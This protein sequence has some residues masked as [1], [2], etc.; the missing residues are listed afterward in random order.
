[1]DFVDYAA[2]GCADLSAFLFILLK[3]H[4]LVHNGLVVSF[5]FACLC[6]AISFG[7]L[8]FLRRPN[9]LNP[10]CRL[11]ITY[12][13][14][15]QMKAFLG[16]A[17]FWLIFSPLNCLLFLALEFLIFLCLFHFYIY[18]SSMKDNDFYDD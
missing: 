8:L 3:Q 15:L 11:I 16:L 14:L 6:F 1:M 13:H 7:H 4:P 2:L 12:L 10:R 5:T 18:N 9:F 17:D